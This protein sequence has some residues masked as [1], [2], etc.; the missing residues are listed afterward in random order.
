MGLSA[1]SVLAQ[2]AEDVLHAHD[3]VVDQFADGHGQ[4]AERHRVDR[5][6]E[7]LEDQARHDDRKRNGRQRDEGRAEV[8]QEQEQ[9][10][11]HEDAAVAQGV[12]DVVDAQF[13]ERLLLVDF[14]G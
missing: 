8:Q 3:G 7:P 6:V 5:H 11:D 12:D 10:D 2:P 1:C 9:D 4:A 14:A 13:D